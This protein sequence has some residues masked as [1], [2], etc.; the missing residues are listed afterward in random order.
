MN[1]NEKIKEVTEKFLQEIEA[2]KITSTVLKTDKEKEE[3]RHEEEMNDERDKHNKE[4]Q[5][6][7]MRLM[8]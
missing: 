7:S 6:L 5:V 8:T 4:L 1:F 2:L 3:I